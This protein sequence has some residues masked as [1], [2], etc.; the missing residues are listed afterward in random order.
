[1]VDAVLGWLFALVDGL[2]GLLPSYELPLGGMDDL[3]AYVGWL[4]A[5]FDMGAIGVAVAA[6]LAV[7]ASLGAFRLALFVWRL[8]PLSG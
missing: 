4:G 2:V 6:I 3:G 8:T 7:E 1:M 5:F